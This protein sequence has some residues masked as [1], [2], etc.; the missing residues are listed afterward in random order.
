MSLADFDDGALPDGWAVAKLE[1]IT[2]KVGS[3]AT[4]KGG[5]E[6]YHK[7]GIPLIRSMNVHFDGFREE[8]L[9]FL[10]S[11]QAATLEQATVEASDVLLNITGASIGRVTQVPVS[12]AGARVNQHVCIIRLIAELDGNYLAKFLSCPAVQEMIMSAEYGVT[13]QALT[14]GQILA[15]DI[16][17]PPLAEQGRIVA[18][19]EELLVRVNAARARL[20][21]VPAL[22]KRLCQSVL[23]AA[24][25]G[26]L[27]AGW[28]RDLGQCASVGAGF[29]GPWSRRQ[30]SDVCS[31]FH[32]G[33]SKKSSKAGKVPVL[34]MGNIQD[35]KIDWS[36]LKYSDD[37]AEIEQYRLSPN[38]VLF[39]RTNS[40]ELVGKTAIYRG[41]R[42]AIFAG[43]LIRV[44]TGP[45]LDPN[46]LNL[47]LN[48]PDF[49]DYCQQVKT[50][51]VSQSNI[52]ASKLA[53]Y[54]MN[55]CPLTEQHE[56]VRRV[57]ALFAL[58]DKIE[59]R[60]RSAAARMEKITQAILTEAFRGELVPTEAELARQEGRS[61][62]PAA[63]LLER[64]RGERTAPDSQPS[65]QKASKRGQSAPSR[66]S[67]ATKKN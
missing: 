53:E 30:L 44:L 57:D 42:P 63:A 41:D 31:G 16:P 60:A 46:F 27:P 2:T 47:T 58:A 51:G 20:A 15:F 24:C 64:I 29:G 54:E 55:W 65:R 9:A 37:D 56:I 3:G 62:E 18:K 1:Q 49:R 19:V 6:A 39:N 35:G 8:G 38:T 36:D 10:D 50:D 61:Y 21:K 66:G 14:K 4:P 17:L 59:A 13:R 33:S 67:R 43:Y 40:P 25:S 22:V 34:R 11:A 48:A 23:A 45:D 52:N 5:S 32:Y 26:A 28:R 7:N 12:M